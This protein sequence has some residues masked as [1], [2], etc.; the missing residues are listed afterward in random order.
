VAILRELLRELPRVTPGYITGYLQVRDV[1]NYLPVSRLA[2]YL[3]RAGTLD[4][5]EGLSASIND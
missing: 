1:D 3:W 2:L 4:K 5:G